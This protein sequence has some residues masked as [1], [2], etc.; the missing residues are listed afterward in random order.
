M[1]RQAVT[2]GAGR[3]EQRGPTTRDRYDCLLILVA[4]DPRQVH[5]LIDRLVRSVQAPKSGSSNRNDEHAV[6]S[7]SQ[8]GW[9]SQ[10]F[11]EIVRSA[12]QLE[13]R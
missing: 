1:T 9:R 13:V 10:G 3:Q 2:I 12:L 11:N 8:T 4:L 6:R 7:G 5:R